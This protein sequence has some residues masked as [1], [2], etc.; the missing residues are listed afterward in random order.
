M[1]SI[2][3]YE[4]TFKDYEDGPNVQD[5]L[6]VYD[7]KTKVQ[8]SRWCGT[9]ELDCKGNSGALEFEHESEYKE[10]SD[11]YFQEKSESDLFNQEWNEEKSE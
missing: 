9:D 6:V 7:I 5:I 10:V 3:G 1:C 4:D 8:T 2:E 11:S